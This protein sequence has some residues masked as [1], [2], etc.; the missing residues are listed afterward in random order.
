MNNK[1]KTLLKSFLILVLFAL[2]VEAIAVWRAPAVAPTGGNIATPINSSNSDQ[3]K[4]GGLTVGFFQSNG[5][6]ILTQ[7]VDIGGT[8]TISS[9]TPGAGKLLTSTNA[10]GAASWS[11]FSSV[12][13]NTTINVTNGGTGLDD[14]TASSV[15]VTTAADTITPF[16]L[17]VGE[18]IKR[19]ASGNGWVAYTPL[20]AGTVTSSGLTMASGKL[21]G[22]YTNPPSAGG[23]QEITV[24]TGL[25]LDSSGNLTATGTSLPSAST[26]DTM[27]VANGT[28]WQ[29]KSIPDCDDVNGNHLNYDTTNNQ[30]SCGN[31]SSTPPTMTGTLNPSSS[32]CVISVGASSCVSGTLTWTT[33]NPQG[34][35]SVTNN[36]TATPSAP[37]GNNSSST[38]T[39]PYLSAFSG[40]TTFYLYNNS[41]LLAQATVTTS[42]AGTSTWNGTICTNTSMLVNSTVASGPGSVSPASSQVVYGSTMTFQTYPSQ[43]NTTLGYVKTSNPSGCP[44]GSFSNFD[45][46]TGPITASGCTYS[47]IFSPIYSLNISKAGSG[48]GT[49]SSVSI[50]SPPPPAGFSPATTNTPF[51]FSNSTFSFNYVEG[52]TVVVRG[53][54]DPGY[55]FTG[56]SGYCSGTSDCTIP[57]TQNRTT[58]GTFSN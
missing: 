30:F 22:R 52:T 25:N 34:T 55:V 13:G 18:S 8:L 35:S 16:A 3:I 58:T 27:L 7:D 19:A 41:V 12:L 51:S 38:F 43:S 39:V 54:A 28:V 21:L 40:V 20:S 50:T 36:G 49:I 10:S 32:S 24:S 15:L 17:A 23:V 37:T 29:I 6:S 33:T 14:M 11:T 31:S 47:F 46:T 45:Y 42:C 56:W 53:T 26:D 2:S 5:V 57:M 48:L 1:T 4:S 44:L 9:G